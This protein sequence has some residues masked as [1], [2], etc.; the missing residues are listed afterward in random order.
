T[1]I[2]DLAFRDVPARIAHLFLKLKEDGEDPA[3]SLSL[4]QKD[5]ANLIGASRE[6]TTTTLNRFKRE[7]IIDYSRRRYVILDEARLCRMLS[8]PA[9]RASFL[10]GR[11]SKLRLQKGTQGHGSG[12]ET[13]P[14]RRM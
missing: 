1:Q 4:S 11:A 13:H 8:E 7:G 3:L 5:I 12:Q 10:A 9:G 2:A 14:L 6:L